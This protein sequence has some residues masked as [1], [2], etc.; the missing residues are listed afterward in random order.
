MQKALL[1][2]RGQTAWLEERKEDGYNASWWQLSVSQREVL[3][4]KEY[5]K[6]MEN[7]VGIISD[8]MEGCER[9]GQRWGGQGS[10]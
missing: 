2:N 6:K 9:S 5:S 8:Q 3:E 10:R 1:G 7:Q 4:E